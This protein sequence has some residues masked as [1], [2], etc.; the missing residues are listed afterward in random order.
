MYVAGKTA[1]AYY[2]PGV[3]RPIYMHQEVHVQSTPGNLKPGRRAPRR[4]HRRTTEG[5]S[6][7]RLRD[8]GGCCGSRGLSGEE[9]DD[10]EGGGG[11]EKGGGGEVRLK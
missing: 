11:E 3:E 1:A 8:M 4:S 7:P 9:G 6:F 10:D 2:V 5:R